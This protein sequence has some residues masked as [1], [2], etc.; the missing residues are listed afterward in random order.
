MSKTIGLYGVGAFG[1]AILKHLDEKS[2][3]DS[4]IAYDHAGTILNSLKSKRAHPYFHPHSTVSERP[5]F[6]DSP[7][8][9]LAQADIVVLAVSSDSTRDVAQAVREH[10]KP[11]VI[12]VNIAKALDKQT[13][14]RLSVVV[15]EALDG[16][17]YYYALLAG[18][19]IA[20]DLFRHEPL[21]VDIACEDR[22]IAEQLADVFGSG[23][24]SVYP[25][26]DLVGVEYAAALKNVISILAGIV[27][28]LGFSYGSE[29]HI[30]SR[31]A[32]KVAKVCVDELGAQERTF[33]IGS[34]SWGND[35]WM[36]CTGQTRNRHY[37]ELV[38]KGASPQD[39]LEAMAAEHKLV[40]GVNT[41]QVIDTIPGLKDIP[42]IAM[43][44]GLVVDNTITVDAIRQQLLKQ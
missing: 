20:D 33:R 23:N 43:L 22:A 30:I 18:G 6:V 12:I 5:R 13:G 2:S 1:Y 14:K 27:A 25:T 42:L 21:G 38:G 17:E 34:Q 35:M 9:L 7:E 19:T 32:H 26:D 37:G 39:A 4:L 28:G 36:S 3:D 31:T 8:E 16:F 24:L 44:H 29:T 11:G 15:S 40:E 41:L 10:A